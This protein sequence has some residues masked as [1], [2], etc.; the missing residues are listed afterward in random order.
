[1]AD[2]R[3]KGIGIVRIW[4]CGWVSGQSRGDGRRGTRRPATGS[5][6]ATLPPSPRLRTS[7][8][9]KTVAVP[10]GSETGR[11]MPQ[12]RMVGT[13]RRPSAGSCRS[14]RLGEA[15]LPFPGLLSLSHYPITRAVDKVARASSPASSSGVPPGDVSAHGGGTPPKPAGEDACATLCHWPCPITRGEKFDL[16]KTGGWG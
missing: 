12:S 6:V 9:D 3:G 2:L 11:V 8:R 4:F 13:A 15:T 1:M 5:V 16:Q 10:R 7:W 14:G